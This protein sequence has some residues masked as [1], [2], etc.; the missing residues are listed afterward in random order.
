M[1]AAIRLIVL[2]IAII[3]SG[4]G[5]QE[6]TAPAGSPTTPK[7]T[8]A[9]VR[10]KSSQPDTPA[11]VSEA[12]ARAAQE[13][14]ERAIQAHAGSAE[15]LDKLRAFISV[16]KGT[17]VTAAGPISAIREVKASLPDLFRLDTRI[18]VGEQSATATL[19]INGLSGW[20]QQVGSPREELP[21]ERLVEIRNSLNVYWLATLIPL[22]D[23]A[24]AIKLLP[25]ALVEGA[26][27]AVLQVT[28]R[29]RPA[30]SLFFDK[31]SGLLVKASYRGPDADVEVL[32]DVS[33]LEHKEFDGLKLPTKEIEYFDGRKMSEWVISD[34]KFPERLNK[35]VF[36]KP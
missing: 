15:R 30:V 31:K 19:A 17:M 28:Q 35:E 9:A 2:G 27:A 3:V 20:M 33:F 21:L 13:I 23:K 6:S 25:D 14:V 7:S 11:V 12:D 34:Y 32:K 8:G 36:E 29:S 18:T 1:G 24:V 16:A 5:C 26:P 10:G 4:S 22:R